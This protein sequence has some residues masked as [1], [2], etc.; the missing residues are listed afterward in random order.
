MR[1]DDAS[2][3]D[4]AGEMV[5][6]A[7][8]QPGWDIFGVTNGGYLMAIAA[9][10]MSEAAGGRLPVSL[11]AHFTRPV[12]AGAVEV[13]VEMV[14]T[15][16]RYSTLR[17]GVVAEAESMALLGSFA[18][19]DAFGDAPLFMAAE[20]PEM[21]PPEECVLIRPAE[22]APIPPPLTD[23]FEERLHPGD[24]GPMVG[25][26]SGNAV[27]RGWFR[28]YDDEAIDPFTLLLVA[29]AFPPAVFN[30]S[31]P[32]AWTPTLE[33][34]TQIRGIPAPGWLRCRFRTRFI[35]GGMLEEDGEIWD[36]SGR[37]V[38]LSRQLALVPR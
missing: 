25:N 17:A 12:S 15:G 1:F 28:L 31:M 19:P 34:T 32:L 38:A 24:T 21:P 18:E 14:K 23:K 4:P 29:D 10:A 2:A 27:V 5:W 6:K 13:S 3:V 8:V 9:R 22:D 33:L 26:P 30:A 37:L 11:T 7:E 20:P 35:T 36:E 16:R